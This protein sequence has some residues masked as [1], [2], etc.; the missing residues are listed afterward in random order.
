MKNKFKIEK[1]IKQKFNERRKLMTPFIKKYG[2]PVIV[3]SVPNSEIFKKIILEKKIRIPKENNNEENNF[4]LEDFLKI[5]NSIYY[6]LGFVYATAYEW[7]FSLIFDL[8]ILKECKYYKNSISYQCS[9]EIAKFWYNRDLNYLIKLRNYNN[10]T[11]EVVDKFLNEKYNGKKRELFDYWKIKKILSKF[12]QNSSYKKEFLQLV[13]F[14]QKNLEV[15]YPF[16]LKEAKKDYLTN[17]AIEILGRKDN[18]ILKNKSFLGFYIVGSIPLGIKKILMQDYS[19]KILFDGVK[20][21][22]IKDL[23]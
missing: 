5:S 19:E 15:K 8:K 17:R 11:R 4:Y 22:Q 7:K 23:K 21:K 9:K 10:K 14:K 13:K 16:S 6:S 12:I 3:H 20:L 2:S 18:N 1:S